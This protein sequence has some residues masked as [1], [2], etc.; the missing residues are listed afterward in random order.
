MMTIESVIARVGLDHLAAHLFIYLMII[1]YDIVVFIKR[2][3]L[4]AHVREMMRWEREQGFVKLQTQSRLLHS[5][6]AAS[7]LCINPR[8]TK[9][10]YV[11]ALIVS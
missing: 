10:N 8:T 4:A 7:S 3:D 11:S 1:I 2:N 5:P 9:N 6:R